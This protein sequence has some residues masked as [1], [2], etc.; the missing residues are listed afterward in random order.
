MKKTL[1]LLYIRD[2]TSVNECTVQ[3]KE[4]LYIVTSD[5]ALAAQEMALVVRT[6]RELVLQKALSS[7][8]DIYDYILIVPHSSV[9]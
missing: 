8:K 9:F 5:I 6:M 3:L 7:V 4:N 1:S 2:G